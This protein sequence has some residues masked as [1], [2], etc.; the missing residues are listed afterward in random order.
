MTDHINP[1]HYRTDEFE[2]IDIIEAFGLNYH[3]GNALKYILRDGRK[4]GP[5]PTVDLEKAAWYI[6]REI[7]N[8]RSNNA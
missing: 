7:D 2:V 6:Q 4:P 8:R 5:S 3:K 1:E